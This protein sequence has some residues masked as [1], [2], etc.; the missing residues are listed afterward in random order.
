MSTWT[1]SCCLGCERRGSTSKTFQK[2][3]RHNELNAKTKQKGVTF[4]MRM[5]MSRE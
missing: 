4:V 1:H 5:P 3:K 2:L